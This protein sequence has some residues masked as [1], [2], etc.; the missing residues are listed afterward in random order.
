VPPPYPPPLAGEGREGAGRPDQPNGRDNGCFRGRGRYWRARAA[1]RLRVRKQ[2]PIAPTPPVSG[3]GR[4]RRYPARAAS[5]T[6]GPERGVYIQM[7]RSEQVRAAAGVVLL[8]CR[9]GRFPRPA[10]HRF[11]RLARR[12]KVRSSGK[13]GKKMSEVLITRN[14]V[15]RVLTGTRCCIGEVLITR[16]VSITR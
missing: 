5:T 14:G 11:A 15:A 6:A 16:N 8:L 3:R 12:E 7:C 13:H 2:R 1:A 9:A 4:M 10:G